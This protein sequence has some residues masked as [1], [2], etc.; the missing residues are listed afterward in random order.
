MYENIHVNISTVILRSVLF[1][2]LDFFLIS[3][4][5]SQRAFLLKTGVLC[6]CKSGQAVSFP[7]LLLSMNSSH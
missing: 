5:Y 3:Q 4:C 1:S 2:E 6:T 7:F